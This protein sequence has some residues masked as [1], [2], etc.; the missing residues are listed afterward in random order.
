MAVRMTKPWVELSPECVKTLTGQLGVYQL[1]DA[2]GEIVFIGFA[3]GRSLFGLRG[4]V[5]KA[6][7]DAPSG[8]TRFRV[9]VNQQYTTR[10]QELLMVHVHDHGDVPTGN[11]GQPL[12]RLGRLSPD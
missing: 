4:E 5:Q 11:K 10:Y 7:G 1:A 9:E 2:K 12:P 6:L 8:A 3:G